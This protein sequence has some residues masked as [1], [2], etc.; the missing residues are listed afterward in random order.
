MVYTFQATTFFQTGVYCYHIQ[1]GQFR[2]FHQPESIFAALSC[3]RYL[4]RFT[5]V[6]SNRC[7]GVGRV[8]KVSFPLNRSISTLKHNHGD[9]FLQWQH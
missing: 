6:D 2:L 1:I 5:L 8:E 3:F 4:L 7:Y 9:R